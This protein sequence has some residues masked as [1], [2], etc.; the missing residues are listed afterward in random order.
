PAVPV[1]V[2]PVRAGDGA[3][4]QRGELPPAPRLR[5]PIDAVPGHG[6]AESDGAGCAEPLVVAFA[7]DVRA[8][9]R[10]VGALGA[11]HG[12]EDQADLERRIAA[13]VRGPDGAASRV[14]GTARARSGVA[15]ECR[16]RPLRHRP[17]RLGR[18]PGRDPRP[19]PCNQE[20]IA[21][22]R[23]AQAE[24][25]WVVEAASAYAAKQ[26]KKEA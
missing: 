11:V 15:V 7:D 2:R 22:R 23:T 8:A 3:D 13:E 14:P 25:A 18:V 26:Q 17:D 12:V 21:A 16:A 24:G 19:G 6:G 20:R 10:G 1:L 4:L 9:G 5:H